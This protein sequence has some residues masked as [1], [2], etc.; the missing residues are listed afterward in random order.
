MQIARTEGMRALNAGHQRAYDEAEKNGIGLSIMWDAT[1]D[2][3]TR[4]SHGALDGKYK[5][6]EHN[7]WYVAELGRYVSGPG[8]SGVASFDINC[9]CRT[10]AHIKGFPPLRK[11]YM[12]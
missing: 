5:N 11:I 7:G 1:L 10:H 6:E 8:Q 12:R 4:P 2:S 3:R 9:R